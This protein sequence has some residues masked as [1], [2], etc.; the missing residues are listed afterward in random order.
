MF[1]IEGFPSNS[2]PNMLEHYFIDRVRTHCEFN[3]TFK[4]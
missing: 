3:A 1:D 2:A 4:I